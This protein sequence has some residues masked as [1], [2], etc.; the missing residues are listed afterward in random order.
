MEW[1]F[2]PSFFDVMVHLNIHLTHEASLAGPVQYR[3][4]SDEHGDRP[5]PLPSIPELKKAADIA[6]RK[7]SPH[8]DYDEEDGSWKWKKPQPP[9]RKM[10][11]GH[12]KSRVQRSTYSSYKMPET[13]IDSATKKLAVVTGAN[14][15]IGLDIC[16][17]LATI[18]LDVKDT[19]SI[20]SLSVFIKTQF[21]KLD[22]LV[23]K[24]GING[25]NLDDDAYRI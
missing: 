12:W 3:W 8:W 17:Q 4:T 25:I 5:R 15:G 2:P 6:E 24:A 18:G 21:G 9:S 16:G 20:A 11:S 19:A 22:I 1:L 13:N 14:K 10:T 23:N 7:E